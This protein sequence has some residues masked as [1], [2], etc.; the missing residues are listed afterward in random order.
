MNI[1]MEV[2]RSANIK[3][4]VIDLLG[5]FLFPTCSLSFGTRIGIQDFLMLW[6][7]FG[8]PLQNPAQPTP[9]YPHPRFFSW[10]HT[11]AR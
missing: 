1:N 11:A 2:S 8:Y 7:S 4:Q 3:P 5:V 10:F 9:P 6:L